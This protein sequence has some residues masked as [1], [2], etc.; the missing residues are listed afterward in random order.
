MLK[1]A[2]KNILNFLIIIEKIKKTAPQIAII[3]KPLVRKPKPI[4]TEHFVN[5]SLFSFSEKR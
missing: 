4:Q 5:S 3:V 2:R 1:I